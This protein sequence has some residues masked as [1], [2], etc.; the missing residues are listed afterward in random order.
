MEKRRGDQPRHERGILYRIPEP[1]AAP[2]ELVVGPP[3]AQR[4]SDG[5][6]HPGGERPRTDPARPGGVDLAFDQSRR[7]E[8]ERNRKPDISEVEERRVER[9]TGI[10][11][12][13]VQ[14][15]PVERRGFDPRERIGCEQHQR[16]ERRG[17]RALHREDPRFQPRR[18][19]A[20]EQRDQAAEQRQH[21]H[22][23]QKRSFVVPPNAGELVE[24]R[25]RRMGVP[26]HQLD[27]E[28]RRRERVGQRREGQGAKKEKRQG[29]RRPGVHPCAPAQACA[30][31]RNNGLEQRRGQR[32]Q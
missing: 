14:V 24:Q 21:Q 28:V 17:D 10:L 12:Q 30:G 20:A 18:K 27:R 16:Q 19:A 6:E 2:A 7:R 9:E 5:Q 11:K 4:D 3:R 29:R 32:G 31:H 22:P 13:R 23:K 25:L 1:P 26:R 8:A 15:V